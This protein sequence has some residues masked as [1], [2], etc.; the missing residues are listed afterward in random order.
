MQHS[1]VGKTLADKDAQFMR[2]WKCM[3]RTLES[4][5]STLESR[6]PSMQG[7]DTSCAARMRMAVMERALASSSLQ[8]DSKVSWHECDPRYP[9]TDLA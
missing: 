4:L 6:I 2:Q 7:S 1:E 9:K 5:R 3:W 8:T